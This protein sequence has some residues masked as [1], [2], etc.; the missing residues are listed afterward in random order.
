NVLRDPLRLGEVRDAHNGTF[1]Y[2]LA[3]Q[4]LPALAA[5]E[6]IAAWRWDGE[7][8]VEI[9]VQVDE[10]FPFFLANAGS[11]FSVYSGTDSELT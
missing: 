10:K 2:P 4:Q 8:F 1:I 11:T 6:D 9:P 5:V 7:R 3:G